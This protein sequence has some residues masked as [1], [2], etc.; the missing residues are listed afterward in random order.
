L[1]KLPYVVSFLI[2]ALFFAVALG[3]T[4]ERA[5]VRRLNPYGH[6]VVVMATLA[7]G[8]FLKGAARLLWGSDIHNVPSPFGFKPIIF[9]L[10][11]IEDIIIAR[12][13]VA[14]VVVSLVIMGIFMLFFRY[15]KLGKMMHATF[16][17]ELGAMLVGINVK[18]MYTTIWAMGTVLC[19]IAAI[20]LVP[21]ST[22]YIEMGTKVML[23]GFAACLL[24]GFGSLIG[25]LI[26]GLA[27]GV[28]ENMFGG[29][30][31]TSLMDI[32]SLLVISLVLIFMPQGLFGGK[33][34]IK[35]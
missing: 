25:A 1:F 30:V 14:I 3:A 4:M 34:V 5:V 16:E 26:G 31:T 6:I 29:Y 28:I 7:I 35:V 8:I 17:T 10:G 24:G 13:S 9:S 15:S 33:V 27:M 21:I 23:K 2:T 19:A 18:R 22:L 32:S 20:L 12:E 11:P